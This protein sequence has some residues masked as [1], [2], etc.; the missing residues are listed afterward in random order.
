MLVGNAGIVTVMSS[1]I[2]TFVLPE[3]LASKLYGLLIIVVGLSTLW[4]A[5]HS[6]W[7][8]RS[9][10]KVIDKMLRKYT[11]LD[12]NDYAAVPHLKDSFKI[13]EASVDNNGW[14]CHRT[15]QELNLREEGITIL[16]VD[17][18]GSGYYGSPSGV[19]KLLPGDIIT[20]YGKS[21]GISSLYNRKKDFY[22][23]LEHEKFVEK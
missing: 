7:V 23:D 22:A 18:K 20:I 1:L 13:I 9:L 6:D 11:D 15:L 14:M 2:L 3:T 5:V 21:E 8:D 16:G 17:R 10:S 4:W 12:M 19:F